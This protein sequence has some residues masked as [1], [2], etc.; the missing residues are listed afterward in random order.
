[1]ISVNRTVLL[2]HENSE[3]WSFRD[4]SWSFLDPNLNHY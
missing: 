3:L 4:G 1:M 2:F